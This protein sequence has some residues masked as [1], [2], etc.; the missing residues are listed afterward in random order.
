MNESM[1][2]ACCFLCYLMAFDCQEIK[3]L[4]TYLLTYVC[5]YYV[6]KNIYVRTDTLQ[7]RLSR[8]LYENV[9][10]VLEKTRQI[11]VERRT[12]SVI[13]TG[14]E[15]SVEVSPKEPN[16]NRPNFFVNIVPF[17]H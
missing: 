8:R 1:F 15:L 9:I 6:C 2:T 17:V 14:H 12:V 4:L 16:R 10:I 5:I 7:H 3:G 11:L 13:A